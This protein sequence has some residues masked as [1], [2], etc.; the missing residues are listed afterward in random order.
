MDKN[1][2]NEMQADYLKSRGVHCPF[3]KGKDIQGSGSLD[4]EA[5]EISQ[6][7]A[8]LGCGEKWIDLYKLSGVQEMEG[9]NHG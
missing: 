5:G 2:T 4:M 6:V 8:C 3:C 1:F 9:T 7:M